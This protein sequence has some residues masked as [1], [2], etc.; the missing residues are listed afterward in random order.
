MNAPA[1]RS[2]GETYFFRDHGQFDLL[3]LRLLPELIER[4]R[5]TG[6]LR[7]WSA[8]CATGEEAYSLAMLVDMLLPQR[9]DRDIHIVGS[10]I[11]EAALARAR[12]GRYRRWSFRLMP[13]DLLQRYFRPASE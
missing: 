13:P 5:A 11:D 7:L 3:R 6:G 4:S 10:D 1:T 2:N 9:D 8:G 12:R